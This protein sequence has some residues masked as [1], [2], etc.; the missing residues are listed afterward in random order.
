MPMRSKRSSMRWRN[1]KNFISE[2]VIMADIKLINRYGF[3]RKDGRTGDDYVNSRWNDIFV[4][5]VYEVDGT[6]YAVYTEL[7]DHYSFDIADDHGSSQKGI[8]FF[9]FP[10]NNACASS[11]QRVTE[12]IEERKDYLWRYSLDVLPQNA[13]RKT[14]E[15]FS[16]YI[17]SM[18]PKALEHIQA[19]QREDQLKK[20]GGLTPN[21]VEITCMG[22]PFKKTVL[23]FSDSG[24]CRAIDYDVSGYYVREALPVAQRAGIERPLCFIVR[25]N[26]KSGTIHN[27]PMSSLLDWS[28]DGN[29]I[30]CAFEEGSPAPLRETEVEAV[31]G[32]IEEFKRWYHNRSRR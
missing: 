4:T 10:I 28:V 8:S 12:L 25:K 26:V 5:D 20:Q 14:E 27:W 32:A 7:V 23:D 13:D 9:V 22:N 6:L 2:V 15:A 29:V 31:M 16:S 19:V 11:A 18:L 3:I 24:I 30:I 21:A 17:V 1:T